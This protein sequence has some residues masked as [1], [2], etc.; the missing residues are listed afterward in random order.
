MQN[1]TAYAIADFIPDAA[2]YPDRWADAARSWR[3]VE[4][5]IGRARLNAA[6]GPGERER[7]FFLY[8][9][10]SPRDD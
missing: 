4:A 9:A 2:A 8:A 6:Y 5:T 3:E 10:R 7:L 1:D